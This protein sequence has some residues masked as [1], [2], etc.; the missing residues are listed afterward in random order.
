M[1]EQTRR[2]LD[3]ILDPGFVR[4]LGDT[5]D[6]ELRSRLRESREEEEEL[7]YVRRLL[8]G[9]LD[10][11]RAELEARKG[12]RGT[13]QALEVLREA[14]AEGSATPNHRGARAPVGA[15]VAASAGRR[16]A[17]RVVSDDH[18]ARLPDLQSDE[19]ESVIGRATDEERR[20]SEHRRKLHA[21]IDTL[22]A[23][24][25]SRYRAGLAPPV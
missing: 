6:D 24:L 2:R 9:R 3:K 1:D 4:G 20:V 21:V 10:I 16:R 13:A 25:A 17:E 12:G 7:S 23:E 5:P 14:L 8:H 18:L 11:L 15:R 19:I 22:E